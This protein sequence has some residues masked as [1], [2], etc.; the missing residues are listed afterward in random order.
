VTIPP[1]NEL[2]LKPGEEPTPRRLEELFNGIYRNFEDAY[3]NFATTTNL[4]EAGAKKEYAGAVNGSGTIE[5]GTAFT[6]SHPSAGSYTITLK[7][8]LS[9]FGVLVPVLVAGGGEGQFIFASGPAT[10]VWTV[11]TFNTAFVAKNSTFTFII[12]QT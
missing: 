8:K 11:S 1:F 6:V 2:R 3:E 9:G 12:R 4:R 7:E 10:Q 5:A